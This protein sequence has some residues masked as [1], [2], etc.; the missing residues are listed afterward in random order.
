M[1][2][3]TAAQTRSHVLDVAS[4]LFYERG[5][6]A[7]S[8]AAQID[9]ARARRDCLDVATL[10]GTKLHPIRYIGPG[11]RTLWAQSGRRKAPERG[12]P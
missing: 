2:R 3:K 1:A 11:A 4:A 12:I 6:R 5:I 7:V 10:H 9:R 8:P